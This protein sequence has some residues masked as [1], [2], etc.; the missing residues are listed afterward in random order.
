MLT[1]QI[2]AYIAKHINNQTIA[3]TEVE[4]QYALQHQLLPN[5]VSVVPRCVDVQVLDCCLKETEEIVASNIPLSLQQP[6]QYIKEHQDQYMYIESS[7]LET[8]LVDAVVLEFDEAF[9]VYM[10]LFG[11]QVQK[12]YG[13]TMKQFLDSYLVGEGLKYSAAFSGE[14]GLWEINITLD[15]L[16]RFCES[17]TVQDALLAVYQAVFALLQHIEATA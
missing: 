6:I 4:Q 2:A 17:W 12:K 8:V 10:A 16:D 9:E 3:L 5:D 1:K 14:D 11:L 13:N 7:L 15:A